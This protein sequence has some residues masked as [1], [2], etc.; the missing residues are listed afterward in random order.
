MIFK[1]DYYIF[2]NCL[3]RPVRSSFNKNSTKYFLDKSRVGQIWTSTV[4]ITFSYYIKIK[5]NHPMNIGQL[6]RVKPKFVCCY[7]IL[8][9]SKQMRRNVQSHK[10]LLKRIW[11]SF[12]QDI[13]FWNEHPF[14]FWSRMSSDISWQIQRSPWTQICPLY[15]N[16]IYWYRST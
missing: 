6:Y 12:T 1:R 11:N 7:N 2:K 5:Y 13:I 4:F 15:V 9:Q 14:K 8:F 16:T 10:Y 3:F